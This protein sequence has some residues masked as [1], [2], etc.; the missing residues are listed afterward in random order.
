MPNQEKDDR[1]DS[2]YSGY[3][4]QD[5]PSERGGR[6]TSGSASDTSSSSSSRSSDRS[7]GT[8][9]A[10]GYREAAESM[11]SVGVSSVGGKTDTSSRDSYSGLGQGMDT[12]SERG[13]RGTVGT[14]SAS[15]SSGTSLAD[16]MR[17]ARETMMSVGVSNLAG[18]SFTRAPT[19]RESEIAGMDKLADYGRG[20]SR[21]VDAGPGWTRVEL[22][23]GTV[24][25]RAGARASRNNNPGNLRYTDFTKAMGAIGTDGQ[26]AVFPDKA[27]GLK[28]MD[29]LL[30]T[31]KYA[32]QTIA[33]AMG[34]YSPASENNTARLAESVAKAV[35]V[36]VDTPVSSLNAAQRAAMI[37]A[38]TRNE[39]NLGYQSVVETAGTKYGT[40]QSSSTRA[41]ASLSFDP[42]NTAIRSQ[43]V[44]PELQE[45]VA[46][47]VSRMGPQFGWVTTSG[48]QP[49]LGLARIGSNRHNNGYALDGALTLDGE[50]I[51]PVS[52]PQEYQSLMA[53]L[54][55]EG[56]GGIGHYG[57]GIHADLKTPN[58]WGP[59]TRS[60]SLDPAFEAAINQGRGLRGLG[61]DY[62]TPTPRGGTPA[63]A[64]AYA[65]G[66]YVQQPSV[67]QGQQQI[68]EVAAPATERFK[69]KY[70]DLPES[71]PVPQ[72]KPE[73]ELTTGQKIA[74]GAIDIG[75]GFIPGVGQYAGLLN[76]G[77]QITGNK[78]IGERVV[79]GLGSSGTVDPNLQVGERSYGDNG[80]QMQEPVETATTTA[81][82]V[83]ST[84]TVQAFVNKYI[85]P[86]PREKW[87]GFRG[88]LA[89]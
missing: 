65:S 55:E 43:P 25:K 20:I 70:L 4:G 61:G 32:G 18:S 52:H 49:A 88:A 12:P 10:D 40:Q 67:S 46:S 3:G 63:T 8:S 2:G 5:S 7:T 81:T 79:R 77:L 37:G 17:Q 82:P 24:E 62:P 71:G 60:A 9:V 19:Y 75:T 80:P 47:A 51:T 23:D 53:N 68:A 73:Q 44:Q 29:S 66:D 15:T 45:K 33:G 11:R 56:V 30:S 42:P 72:A 26:F 27:T 1:A 84:P 50:K 76:A 69:E 85:G 48:G 31:E 86:T 28:A 64:T 83:I 34:L 6:G 87:G 22:L 41:Q 21:V 36:P 39:G 35:G 89:S 78:T 57:W 14:A 59:D 54:A 38:I 16:G 58:A 74:A 13:G